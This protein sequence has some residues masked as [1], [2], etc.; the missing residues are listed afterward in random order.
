MKKFDL[1]PYFKH[2]IT[3]EDVHAIKP[4]PQAYILAAERLGM[5]PNEC[6]VFEDTPRGVLAAH[7]AGMKC[8]AIPTSTTYDGDFSK[9]A[10]IAGSLEGMNINI[11]QG[12]FV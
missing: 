4:D 8:I 10:M 2:I 11:L 12:L 9:A 6:V 3:W 1:R 5:Q 7:R